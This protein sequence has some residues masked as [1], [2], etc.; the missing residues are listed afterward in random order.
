MN[1]CEI[2]NRD[3]FNNLIYNNFFKDKKIVLYGTGNYGKIMFNY[4]RSKNIKIECFSD[5]DKN[6]W[7]KYFLN[8]AIIPPE[9]LLDIDNIC[10]V[11][12]SM[13]YKDI[14]NKLIKL[15]LKNIYYCQD[16]CI[17]HDKEIIK[18]SEFKD[19]HIFNTLEGNNLI[20]EY[21]SDNKQ[22]MIAHLGLVELEIVLSYLNNEECSEIKR[23]KANINAGIFPITN[24]GI[25][26]FCEIYLNSLK[27]ADIMNVWYYK[28][29][30]KIIERYC[31][32]NIKLVHP[33]CVQ[34]FFV[35]LPWMKSLEN[36]KVLVIHPFTESIKKQYQKREK[37]FNNKDILPKFD[38][39]TIKAV[40]SSGG[41]ITPYKSWEDSLNYMYSEIDKV[42]FDIALIGAG[43]YGLPLAAYVR[44]IGKTAIHMGSTI[45]L[46]FGIEGSRW[47]EEREGRLLYNEN[48]IRP[49]IIETPPNAIDIE[50]ACYW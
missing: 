10:I 26:S 31:N 30:A 14:I 35:D 25:I 42:D 27:Y 12:S 21:I 13:Y 50:N 5:S 7:G 17:W 48:W 15:G 43:A 22:F 20:R 29:E 16:F 23:K 19:K 49:S 33:I 4:F 32:K 28:N 41:N 9:E 8:F 39:I 38:L 44:K 24:K 18:N 45:Q 40:Q 37:L 1:A 46:M 36:K 6:R 11:I 47:D 3:E 34:P 2:I